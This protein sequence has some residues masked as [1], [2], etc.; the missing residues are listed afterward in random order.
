MTALAMVATNSSDP[1]VYNSKIKEIANGVSGATDVHT[2]KE[3]V[4]ALHAGKTIRFVGAGGANNFD[5]YNNS[6][7]GYIFVKYDA[8]GAEVQVAQMT[9]AQT[10][11]ISQAGGI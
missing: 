11:T 2:Y 7:S 9:P 5:Q 1:T 3:G 8:N 4:D 10:Q 6:Q